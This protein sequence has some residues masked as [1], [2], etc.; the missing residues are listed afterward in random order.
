MM[1]IEVLFTPAEFNALAARDLSR[2]TAVVFD[3]LRATTSMITALANGA[4]SVTPAATLEEALAKRAANPAVL[5]AG[6][7]DGVRLRAALT[8]GVDFD[9]GNSPREFTR[10][11]IAGRD[12]VMTTTNGTRALRACASARTVFPAAFINLTATAEAVVASQPDQILLIG[13]GTYEDAAFEDTLAAGAMVE[14][15]AAR[16]EAV[17]LLDSASIAHEIWRVLRRDLMGAMRH[18]RNGTRLLGRPE[19]ADDVPLCLERDAV[20]LVA[21]QSPSGVITAV[22]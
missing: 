7:R 1:E 22:S 6:E 15:L 2:T 12:L 21:V 9:F 8:G 17:K 10:E 19:L 4:T 13:S 5:L 16:L 11:A 14:E 20:S 18:S 3:I